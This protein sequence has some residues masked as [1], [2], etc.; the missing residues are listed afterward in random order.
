MEY[1]NPFNITYTNLCPYHFN[2]LT[3]ESFYPKNK[4]YS[5][6]SHFPR[7]INVTNLRSNTVDSVN[8]RQTKS[9]KRKKPA[10]YRYVTIV[11]SEKNN[12]PNY[13]HNNHSFDRN[14]LII[15]TQN[16]N[17]YENKNRTNLNDKIL[18]EV[19]Y[20]SIPTEIPIRVKR[21]N[22]IRKIERFEKKILKEKKKEKEPN[23]IKKKDKFVK[24]NIRE[25]LR[26]NNRGGLRLVNKR[27]IRNTEIRTSHFNSYGED[28]TFS[29]TTNADEVELIKS[30]KKKAK[31]NI[32]IY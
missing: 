30:T 2:Q 1:C 32:N 23:Y 13:V 10:P 22:Y 25:N 9:T 18:V 17:L 4:K 7:F 8:L 21:P 3:Q 19:E 5:K 26:E 28:T 14:N 29:L 6:K 11:Y 20:E 27:M 12:K 24:K 16:H 15:E 31:K